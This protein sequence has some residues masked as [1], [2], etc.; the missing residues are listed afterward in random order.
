MPPS[1]EDEVDSLE[2]A[3]ERL[4]A[5]G[6]FTRSPHTSLR[7]P[8]SRSLPH[9]WAE[10]RTR[11]PRT[12]R[13]ARRLHF[14]KAFFFAAFI[15]FLIAL[16]VTAYLLYSGSN[17]VS[18]DKVT[19]ALQGPTTVAAGDVVP[20]LVSI[21]NTNITAI[22]H[23]TLEIDF[24]NGTKNPDDATSAYPRYTEDLG[25]LASGQA[26][27]RSV[28]A[29]LF[30]APGDALTLPVS[31]SYSIASSNATFVKKTSYAITISSSPLSVSIGAPS[32]VPAG[33][34]FTLSLTVRSN[35]PVPIDNVILA[36]AFP[37]GFSMTDS[38]PS[39]EGSTLPLGTLQPGVGKTVTISGTLTG[40]DNDQRVFR[41]TIGTTAGSDQSTV[42]VAYM[43]QEASVSIAV[44][45][46]A[47]AL[48]L[49]GNTS[50]TAILAP[51]SPQNVTISYTN[52]LPVSIANANVTITISG[53]AVDYGSIQASRGFYRSSD[54]AIVFS[55]DTDTSL[56]LLAPGASGVGAFSF[57]TLA[58]GAAG[59]SPTVSF[60]ITTAGTP[61]GQSTV[62]E[63]ASASV[64]KTFKVATVVLLSQSALHAAGPFPNTGPIPPI[65]NQATTYTIS[66]GVQNT[67]SALAGGVVA[68]S[69]PTYVSYTGSATDGISYDEGSHTVTWNVGNL[70]QGASA[71]GAFQVSFTPS[72]SQRGSAP[73]LTGAA[74]FS[75]YDRF[76]GANVSAAANAATTATPNDP[77]Y[78]ATNALVQ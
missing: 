52:T 18:V 62:S 41:F 74:S 33:K 71:S 25:T 19:V 21:T 11:A 3:R 4:Y 16:G 69:L 30:G 72:T 23:A 60:T 54:H 31:L 58:P 8:M 56:T 14:A 34:P 55:R 67:G 36:G 6:A 20:L 13:T 57:S 28:R 27:T 17:A 51:G 47:T 26:V 49:N 40:Q 76:A 63:G 50:D 24:P 38:S 22:E 73:V 45:F 5:P 39:F 66:L 46:I 43:T 12:P 75:G 32:S 70:A 7:V 61:S 64:T 48:T 77:G 9:E 37:F 15:F 44:P 65:A 35:A 42:A 78:T 2:R 10:S 1:R 59:P 29:L 53:P 68:T